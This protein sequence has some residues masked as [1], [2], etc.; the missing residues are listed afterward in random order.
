M[1]KKIMI[2]ASVGA[3]V[4][5]ILFFLIY[6]NRIAISFRFGHNPAEN[7]MVVRSEKKPVPVWY[8]VNGQ[9]KNDQRELLWSTS[10]VFNATN[11]INSWLAILDQEEVVAQ[12]STIQDVSFS[13]DDQ[14]LIVSLDRAPFG[15]DDAMYDKLMLIESLLKTLRG[16]EF[17]TQ[18]VR[19]L[20]HHQPLHDAHLDFT[21][22][23]PITGFVETQTYPEINA[24]C[25]SCVSHD[26]RTPITIVLDPAGD[27][28]IAG[29][30]IGDS[31]ERSLTFQCMDAVKDYLE[32]R[33]KSVRVLL[34]RLP[35]E[36]LEPLQN[37]AFANRLKADL[38]V[39]V[40]M[41]PAKNKL[42][43]VSLFYNTSQP[44]I[45]ACSAERQLALKPYNEGTDQFQYAS[46]CSAAVFER[47]ITETYKH[48]QLKVFKPLGVPCK[49]LS[50]V[51][52]PAVAFELGVRTKDEVSLSAEYIGHA[53][54]NLLKTFKMY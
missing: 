6:N 9:L 20:V 18:R 27:A 45:A 51:M 8:W 46:F 12:P 47:F 32:S 22:P 42:Y 43:E 29:R 13:G 7:L 24:L 50:G 31:Y 5:G 38:Y 4:I 14:E 11:V 21:K 49:S 34:T 39:T 52:A 36:T 26:T 23:W 1:N 41:Y 33:F 17:P 25:F 28:R 19:F 37:V 10:A 40:A 15:H 54:E 44:G 48:D 53:I 16:C 30:V 2:A 35:G 3:L